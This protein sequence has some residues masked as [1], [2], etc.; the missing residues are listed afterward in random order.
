M[1]ARPHELP[2]ELIVSFTSYPPRFR[3]LHR[4]IRCLVEQAVAPDRI[5]LWL[6][7]DDVAELPQPLRD[8]DGRFLEIR[9]CDDLRSYKK[10][11][12]ALEAFPGAWIVTADDDVQYES[13]WLAR[14]VATAGPGVVNCNRAHR[15]KSDAAGRLAPFKTWEMNVQDEAARRPSTDLMP[16]GVAGILYPPGCLDPRVTDRETFQRL[17]PH[18]DDLW[19]YWC[20][21]MAGTRH[22]KVGDSMLLPLWPG[23]QEQTLWADNAAGGNDRMIAALEGEFP[24]G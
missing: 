9:A 3:T 11:V 16:I 8:L 23:S 18:G 10:L 13:D 24:L 5:V 14:L 4:T 17:A 1:P 12:P 2:G 7:R 20:A 15:M 21:R 6:A 22:R 19:F